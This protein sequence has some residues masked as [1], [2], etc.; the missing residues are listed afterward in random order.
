MTTLLLVA[1]YVIFDYRTIYV[2]SSIRIMKKFP[3]SG[4]D[5]LVIAKT[6]EIP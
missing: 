4:L 6:M 2:S 1:K 5:W 3:V